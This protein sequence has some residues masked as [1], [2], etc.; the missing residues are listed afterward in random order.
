MIITYS[1]LRR[2]PSSSSSSS[3]NAR[4]PQNIQTRCLHHHL[5]LRVSEEEGE[6]FFL[7]SEKFFRFL[8]LLLPLPTAEGPGARVERYLFLFI[9]PQLLIL[10]KYAPG[11]LGRPWE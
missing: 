2:F 11:A 9:S 3:F 5:L 4:A 6:S 10:T 7:F 1:L 8:L